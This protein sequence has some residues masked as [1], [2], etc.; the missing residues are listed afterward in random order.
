M[1]KIRHCPESQSQREPIPASHT[2]YSVN[3][4]WAVPPVKSGTLSLLEGRHAIVLTNLALIK[5]KKK[6]D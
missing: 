3:K 5:K 6:I 4:S 1:E 2:G